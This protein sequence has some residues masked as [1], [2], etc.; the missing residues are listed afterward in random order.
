MTFYDFPEHLVQQAK[1][2]GEAYWNDAGCYMLING[3]DFTQDSQVMDVGGY[4][5]N[6]TANII[7]RYNCYVRVYEPVQ[8]YYQYC[9]ERF[10][11]N[12]KVRVHDYGLGDSESSFPIAGM[13]EGSSVFYPCDTGSEIVRIGDI[14][15]EI[16][17]DPNVNLLALNCEG[18]EYPILESLIKSGVIGKIKNILVQFHIF[19]PDA[20]QR[21]NAIREALRKTHKEK[22]NYPYTWES[23]CAF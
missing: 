11:N 3:Y 9:K 7:K 1:E 2:G 15:N 23:W 14:Q 12:N 8:K 21:R 6:F 4:K 17:W 5:G 18:G 10:K 16:G 20:E 13:D 22:F 19:V